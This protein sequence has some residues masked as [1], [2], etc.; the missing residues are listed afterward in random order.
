MMWLCSK[1]HGMIVH[2]LETG[3]PLCLTIDAY[4]R[5]WDI[6]AKH[7]SGCE[8]TTD[9]E[10]YFECPSCKSTDCVFESFPG[11]VQCNDCAHTWEPKGFIWRGGKY[12]G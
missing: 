9:I 3:C 2:S 11:R 4:D 8:S 1:N 5:L 10:G 6:H 7:L 12:E